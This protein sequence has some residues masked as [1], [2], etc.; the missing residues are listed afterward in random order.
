[1]EVQARVDESSV[2]IQAQPES[3]T[4]GVQGSLPVQCVSKEIQVVPSAHEPVDEDLLEQTLERLD[5]VAMRLGFD[6]GHFLTLFTA[7]VFR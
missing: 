3:T 6:I 5:E 4:I 2:G 1:M 7:A